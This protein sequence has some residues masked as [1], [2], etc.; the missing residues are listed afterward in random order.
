MSFQLLR[1][2]S[3]LQTA[4]KQIICLE[5]RML[6]VP[7]AQV[8]VQEG[9]KEWAEHDGL[10]HIRFLWA[11]GEHMVLYKCWPPA[12]HGGHCPTSAELFIK[13]S[14]WTSLCLNS[15]GKGKQISL[16]DFCRA[17]ASLAHDR[18]MDIRAHKHWTNEEITTKGSQKIR[19]CSRHG[20]WC[21]KYNPAGMQNIIAAKHIPWKL[22]VVSRAGPLKG[23][24]ALMAARWGNIAK[25]GQKSHVCQFPCL[26]GQLCHVC[27]KGPAHGHGQTYR[28]TSSA[29][30]QMSQ[31][32]SDSRCRVMPPVSD[33]A[34]DSD[35]S[36]CCCQRGLYSQPHIPQA[37]ACVP[38]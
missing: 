24:N 7:N 33:G 10:P 2:L 25:S 8:K 11:S 36:L 23:K 9:V 12:W 31:G 30:A 28:G 5:E 1:C 34:A 29:Q 16:E 19:H 15:C 35:C 32:A 14:S 20:C 13:Y 21:I 27:E 17:A 3:C 22:R 6:I 4:S 37:N 18:L 38:A 26:Q